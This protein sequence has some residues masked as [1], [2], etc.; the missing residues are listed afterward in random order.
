MNTN[1]N[2]LALDDRALV[3]LNGGLTGT[4]IGAI[5]GGALGAI[6]VGASAVAAVTAATAIGLPVVVGT[7]IFEGVCAACGGAFAGGVDG[8]A[9]GW[10]ASH[11]ESAWDDVKSW[12]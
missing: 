5:A 8:A 1:A 6:A 10:V 12:F 7:A 2:V 9:V 4:E 11:A 3:A